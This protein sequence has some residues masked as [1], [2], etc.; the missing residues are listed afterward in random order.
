MK[1][2]IR[3]ALKTDILDVTPAIIAVYDTDYNII[4]VNKAYQEATGVSLQEGEGKK[5]YS[6]W[7]LERPCRDCPVIKAIKTGAP[8]K[9]E[10]TPQNQEW[11]PSQ[12]SWLS[13]GSPV[14]DEKGCIIGAV[15]TLSEIT[16]RIQEEKALEEFYT[17]LDA[18]MRQRTAKLAEAEEMLRIAF[19]CSPIGKALVT[20]EG[21]F[22]KINTALCRAVGYS[23]AEL[24]TKTF[25]EITHSEDLEPDFANLT[26]LLAGEVGSY[27]REKRYLHKQG[28]LI[29]IQV[30]VSLV[31]DREGDPLFFIAQIQDI[32]RRKQAE[33]ELKESRDR[34]HLL[35]GQLMDV[36]W[37]ATADGA[38]IL[39]VNHAFEMIYGIS[40][41]DFRSNP[42]LW[43]EMVHPDDKAIAE[44]STEK[45]FKN[46][47][48]QAEYRIVRPDGEIRWIRDRKTLMHDKE[49]QPVLIGGIGSDITA[50]KTQEME[51]TKLQ[52]QL[53]QAQKMESVG[54]LAGGVAHDYNNMLSVITGYTE[55][56]MDEVEPN[57]LIH[58]NLQEIL[59]AANRS[60]DITR[61]LLAFA[62]KQ[63]IAPEVVDLNTTV[64]N[65]LKML[66]RLIGEDIDLVW[67]AGS[68][69]WTIKIDPA[70]LDQILA[71][72]CVNAR[73]A[74]ADVGKITIKTQNVVFDEAYCAVHKGFLPGEYVML[75]LRDDGDGM[76]KE[77]R[78]QIFDPFFTT[79]QLGR[80]TGLGLSIVYGIVKQNNGFINV[81]SE[82]GEG[83]TFE[84]YFPRYLG[85]ADR[86][87]SQSIAEIP[88]GNG[89]TVLVVEDEVSILALMR[90][91]LEGLNYRVLTAATPGD[92]LSMAREHSEKILLLITDVV[93]P[94]MN[95]RELAE[96]LQVLFPALKCLFMS[97]YTANVIARHGVLEKGVHFLQ[98]PASK[99]ELA[100][101]VR[102]VL[103]HSK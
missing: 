43:F 23:E 31:C 66:R 26:Q 60:A 3:N 33:I 45:L 70:Q 79:K 80:G 30:N 75:A 32:T 64:E 46:G 98:K 76:N 95:G 58:E 90:K 49:G 92:A 1:L 19:E 11:L 15:A 89:E 54:R 20:I 78:D 48:A 16:D 36:T 10:L 17:G 83:T 68:A 97:G 28:H 71:N 50:T 91:I 65:M 52:E 74:I 12:G 69:L 40:E 62:R 34:F 82:L 38:H 42:G 59:S 8:H 14:K 24:L 77:T 2:A 96:Q 63:T 41:A 25:Q 6:I 53:F 85:K 94:G 7:G 35:T 84:L 29:W 56:A 73:D 87:Q 9:A 21:Q 101:K 100:V 103:E 88:H 86:S 99:R 102:D 39:D 44:A 81:C 61:Q 5:C 55:L 51:K 37:T 72:L 13:K 67:K 47:Q 57:D 18:Q 22:L 27:E 4:W 93:M